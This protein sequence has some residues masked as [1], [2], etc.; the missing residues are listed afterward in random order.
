MVDVNTLLVQSFN[1]PDFYE[2]L[3]KTAQSKSQNEFPAPG[4]VLGLFTPLAIT[5]SKTTNYGKFP[6]ANTAIVINSVEDFQEK[7]FSCNFVR[8]CPPESWPDDK[9]KCED[10]CVEYL[11]L[12]SHRFTFSF[13]YKYQ[14]KA[15]AH[16]ASYKLVVNPEKNEIKDGIDLLCPTQA[17]CKALG[18]LTEEVAVLGIREYLG[19]DNT[20]LISYIATA[21]EEALQE[22]L[23]AKQEAAKLK[24]AEEQR[25]RP[26]RFDDLR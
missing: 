17:R 19:L 24:E 1:D 14:D 4:S 22:A 5:R 3:Q 21:K 26:I 11:K 12:H 9:E 7:E 18:G 6:L 25:S 13:K 23:K 8:E 2:A 10:R 16:T 15:G 20:L